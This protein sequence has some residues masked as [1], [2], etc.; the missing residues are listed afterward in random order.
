MSIWHVGQF[1]VFEVPLVSEFSR[2]VPA[3]S[4][5]PRLESVVDDP[6][7]WWIARLTIPFPEHFDL[8]RLC[9]V[10]R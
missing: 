5:Q 4:G 8:S 7:Q 10:L 6:L 2:D 3:T 1:R 9:A